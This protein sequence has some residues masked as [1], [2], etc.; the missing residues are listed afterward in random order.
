MASGAP[1]P[2]PCCRHDGLDAS[3]RGKREK[4]EERAPRSSSVEDGAAEG[5]DEPELG[6]VLAD[7]LELA[8][9]VPL[10]PAVGDAV[11][12]SLEDDGEV[13][14]ENTR[15]RVV[16]NSEINMLIDTKSEVA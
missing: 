8:D 2:V 3:P 11:T 4:W 7:L 9:A 10:G 1:A 14:S 5:L 16:L 13:H 15:G 6:V 12:G